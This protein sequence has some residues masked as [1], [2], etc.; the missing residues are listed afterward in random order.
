MGA[1][2]LAAL[3]MIGIPPTAGFFS[4][5]YLVLGGIDAGHWPAVG[6]VL[7]STLL[8]A[9]YF[10]RVL[11][12]VYTREPVPEVAAVG[13]SEPPLGMLVPTWVLGG[14]VLLLGLGNVL[15]VGRVLEQVARD[16]VGG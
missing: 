2:T 7:A 5:W 10:F 15:I 11:E 16:L 9:A 13:G 4:K 6:V 12:G 3:A 8:T 14:G 1:F